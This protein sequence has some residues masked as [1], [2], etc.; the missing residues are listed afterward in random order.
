MTWTRPAQFSAECSVGRLV[1]ARLVW[2]NDATDV[3]RFLEEMRL[4]FKLAGSSV[5]C[6][7]WRRALVLPPSASDALLELLRQGNRHFVRSAI[8]LA[9]E[10]AV[11][12]LQVE[13]LVRWERTLLLT[14]S[15]LRRSIGKPSAKLPSHSAS[16]RRCSLAVL[17]GQF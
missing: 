3:Q 1:E 8:L 6:A 5:I 12:G 11:F 10:N 4:A 2:V 9:P 13:R 17:C 15:K 7:D 16:H 14:V